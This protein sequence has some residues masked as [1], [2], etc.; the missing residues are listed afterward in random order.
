ME[1]IFHVFKYEMTKFVRSGQ[2]LTFVFSVALLLF[3]AVFLGIR[4]YQ[5]L[6]TS[7]QENLLQ[8]RLNWERQA[9]KDPH[10][11]AHDGTYL[12]KPLHPLAVVDR[13]VQKYSGQ[14]IHLRAHERQQSSLSQVKD[15]TG[16]YRFGVLTPGF[17]LLYIFPLLI[18]FLGYGSF[19]TEKETQTLPLVKSQ[20]VSMGHIALGKWSALMALVLLL[21]TCFFAAIIISVNLIS[22][23]IRVDW[24]DWLGIASIYILYFT[25]FANLVLLVSIFARSSGASLVTSLSLWILVALVTPKMST[26]LAGH[27]YP[28][29]TYQAFRENINSDQQ[30]GL[31]GHNFWNEAAQDFQQQVLQEYGVDS[32]EELPVDYS[33]LLLAEGEKYESEI[34]SK[35][36]DLLR[37]Q[38]QNQRA[39]YRLSS[40]L[41]PF[42]SVRFVS[43]AL[44]R[45]DY[46]FQWHFEDQ[47]EKYRVYFNTELNM[48]IAENAK[49]VEGYT[50]GSDLWLSIDRFNYSWQP[51]SEILR[52][53]M[54]D[55]TILLIWVIG[56]FLGMYLVSRRGK[57]V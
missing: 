54:V 44:A 39:I 16:I 52:D 46:N 4:E 34:Y 32:I 17:V 3:A 40:S 51:V 5:F 29:P 42:L 47:A 21:F 25:F 8:S 37:K 10:D 24:K 22:T 49:G 53:H 55:Y 56:S 26:N 41:S 57:V 2:S 33:G 38:Y 27:V 36:F 28:F 30:N 50:A 7:Y 6:Q 45:S 35:H 15:Q 11:A 31:N 12:I 13:G 43:M 14:V 48:N 9:Q 1:M 20:G 23:E 18:I 19:A